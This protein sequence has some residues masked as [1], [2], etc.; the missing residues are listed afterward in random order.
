VRKTFHTEVSLKDLFDTPTVADVAVIIAQNLAGK[1]T[2]E[3]MAKMLQELEG[4]TEKEVQ[5]ILNSEGTS[6]GPG[7][8]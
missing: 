2:E 8:L 7:Q 6:L 4:M 3:E 5:G 1:E